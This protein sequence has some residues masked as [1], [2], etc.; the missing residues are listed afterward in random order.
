MTD[1][2]MMIIAVFIIPMS[3]IL[4]FKAILMSI[5]I[6]WLSIFPI[7]ISQRRAI[8]FPVPCSFLKWF[9]WTVFFCMK[10]FFTFQRSL[11]P[12]HQS[13][14]GIIS[15][16]IYPWSNAWVTT[17]GISASQ[18]PLS[19]FLQYCSASNQDNSLASIP[20][21]KHPTSVTWT[22]PFGGH[23]ISEEN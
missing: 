20:K 4:E 8:S 1:W 11:A 10:S 15:N 18:A 14:V 5:L 13:W 2:S 7:C 12:I 19:R 3:I 21:W 22:H 6:V 9:F 16:P 23:S 17:F